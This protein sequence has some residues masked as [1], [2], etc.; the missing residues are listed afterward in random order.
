[1]RLLVIYGVHQPCTRV[2]EYSKEGRVAG[3]Q[4]AGVVSAPRIQ[5]SSTLSSSVGSSSQPSF[6]VRFSVYSL[7]RTQVGI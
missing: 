7:L 5:R 2:S 3:V 6:M 1:M 4:A